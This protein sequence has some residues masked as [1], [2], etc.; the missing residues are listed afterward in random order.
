MELSI[1]VTHYKTPELL[2]LCLRSLKEAAQGITYEIL[3]LDSESQEETE[4]IIN[5]E[6]PEITLFL[7]KK[8]T[9]Y[10]KIVNVGLKEAKGDYLLILN[11]DIVVAKDSL[12]KMMEYLS[13]NRKVGILG[14]RLLNFNG[15]IQ[16]SC[17]RFYRLF[18]V[19]YRRTFLGKT[20][21][22][23]KELDRFE[24]KDFDRQS[25]REVDWLLGAA[26][27]IKRQAL[28]E[29]GPM[30][31]RFF[32]YFEDTDWCLRFWKKGWSAV[33]LSDAR[34]HHYH[35]RLSKKTKGVADLFFNKYTWIH[36][37]SAIKYFWKWRGKQLTT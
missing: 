14:P 2:K 36:I 37:S 26:M 9:G 3:V 23:K 30:D 28:R 15:A 27:M 11:A 20:N 34:M 16:E 18:T 1:I 7:F 5:N 17:F 6:W 24:M 12:K 4:E 8:N 13:A 21:L 29:V 25:T 31:E 33:Y 35:G 10:A 32:L 19:I 22:G